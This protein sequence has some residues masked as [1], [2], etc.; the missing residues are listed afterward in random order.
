MTTTA[1]KRHSHKKPTCLNSGDPRNEEECSLKSLHTLQD[2]PSTAQGAP[3]SYLPAAPGPVGKEDLMISINPSR[4]P[5]LQ[6]PSRVDFIFFFLCTLLRWDGA[7][8]QRVGWVVVRRSPRLGF[9]SGCSSTAPRKA[10]ESCRS[11]ADLRKVLARVKS[12]G[13]RGLEGKKGMKEGM[14]FGYKQRRE[15]GEA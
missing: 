9:G 4:S 11:S 5:F 1:I 12:S 8:L 10:S 3:C 6:P 15:R 7:V 2:P 13:E 14:L